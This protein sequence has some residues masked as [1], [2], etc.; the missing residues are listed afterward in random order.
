MFTS[1]LVVS[2]FKTDSGRVIVAMVVNQQQLMTA[3][4]AFYR[5]AKEWRGQYYAVTTKFVEAYKEVLES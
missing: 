1:S 4:E 5:L 3:Y 2:Q